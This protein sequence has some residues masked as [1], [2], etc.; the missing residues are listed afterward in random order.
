M[1]GQSFTNEHGFFGT[2]DR[3]PLEVWEARDRYEDEVEGFD[4]ADE[5]LEEEEEEDDDELD[6][7]DDDDEDEEEEEEE[8]E[9]NDDED[10]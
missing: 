9:D 4:E 6:D 10:D 1:T 8:V 2:S 3:S 7:D 5:D